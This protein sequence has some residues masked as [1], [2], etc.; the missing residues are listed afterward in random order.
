MVTQAT[1]RGPQPATVR[2]LHPIT[3][4]SGPQIAVRVGP[5]LILV[6][7]RAALASFVQAWLQADEMG[8]NAFV[9]RLSAGVPGVSREGGGRPGAAQPRP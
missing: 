4:G 2:T 6:A 9:K 5:I 1:V 3:G 7:D 8:D